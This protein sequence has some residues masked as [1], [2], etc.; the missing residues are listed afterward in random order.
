MLE[1]ASVNVC[2]LA[3]WLYQKDI[4]STAMTQVQDLKVLYKVSLLI[5]KTSQVIT[6]ITE[7]QWNPHNT[8]EGAFTVEMCKIELFLL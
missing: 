5:V 8:V 6:A 3:L 7:S 4:V 2:L 1:I